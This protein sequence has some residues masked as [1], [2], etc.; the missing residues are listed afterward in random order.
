[1]QVFKDSATGNVWE[2]DSDVVVTD[3]NGVYSLKTSFGLALNTPSTLQPY[4]IPAPTA[5]QQLAAAQ[6]AQSIALS[7]A[8]QTAIYA[9]FI[10]SALG[11]VHTYP[12]KDIDQQNLSASVLNSLYPNLPTG[13]PTPFWCADSNGNWAYLPH[14]AAQI[15][16]AGSDGKSAILANLTKNATLQAQ[17]AAIGALPAWAASTAQAVNSQIHDGNGNIWKCSV[18]GTTGATAP[19]WPA[20]PA[21]GATVTDG[22]VTWVF[23]SSQIAAVLAIIW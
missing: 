17:I 2:F 14:T 5:A 23:V 10:S 11:A 18:A 12:A 13:W 1:M 21:S 4:T 19:V 6:S 8:C 16:Q 9:G 7:A 22:A 15:Q 3:T 20:S